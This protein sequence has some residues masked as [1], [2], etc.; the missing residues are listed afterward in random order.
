LNVA[1][2]TGA[3]LLSLSIGAWVVVLFQMQRP[4]FWEFQVRKFDLPDKSSPVTGGIMFM[5]SSSIRFWKT[6]ARDMAPLPI[7]NRGFGGAHIFHLTHFARRIIAP[8]TPKA[9]VVHAGENELGWTSRKSPE[10][11]LEDFRH[12]VDLVQG[13]LKVPRVYFISIKLSPPRRGRW[14]AV[15]RANTLIEDFARTRGGVT[16]IDIAEAMLDGSGEPRMELL[17]WDR[18]HLSERGYALW[19]SII[20]PILERDF[21]IAA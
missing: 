1:L 18:F 2:V 3:I 12:F 9:I 16:F 17:R 5:G 15:R 19:T 14:E 20:K 4:N 21:Q 13:E 8:C 7:I 11:V 6:L 10:S